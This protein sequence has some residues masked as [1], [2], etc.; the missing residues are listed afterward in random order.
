MKFTQ[1]DFWHIKFS[2][3]DKRKFWEVVADRANEVL[4]KKEAQ[5]DEDLV[6]RLNTHAEFCFP[7]PSSEK[8]TK[9]DKIPS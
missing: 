4:A 1:E 7:S 2:P 6:S 5:E 3:T 8:K 9:T